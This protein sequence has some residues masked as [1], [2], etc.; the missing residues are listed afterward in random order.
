MGNRLKLY[1]DVIRTYIS[2]KDKLKFRKIAFK[3]KKTVSELNRYLIHLVIQL[4]D[5]NRLKNQSNELISFFSK[6]GRDS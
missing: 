2:H 5:A 6:I 4:N 1:D 3:H